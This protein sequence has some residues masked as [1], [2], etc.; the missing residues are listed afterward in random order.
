MKS[1]REWRKKETPKNY[2]KIKNRLKAV[3]VLLGVSLTLN[4]FQLSEALYT[5]EESYVA[6]KVEIVKLKTDNP[7]ELQIRLIA[8]EENFKDVEYLVNLAYCESRL[9]PYG[10]NNRNN[11]PADSYD[12]GLFQYNSYWQ[13]RI[14][15][16]CAFNVDCSTRE[17]IKMLKKG[18]HS[19]WAC[20]KYI[21]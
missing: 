7:V 12:R 16:A 18:Q 3:I 9:D 13:K 21:R 17:T 20:D 2:S 4:A 1:T 8:E 11:Y 6:Y 5:P 10:I 19:L 15:N 14:S